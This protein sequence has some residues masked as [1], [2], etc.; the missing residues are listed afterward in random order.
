MNIFKWVKNKKE[1]ETEIEDLTANA[2]ADKATIAYY[3]NKSRGYKAKAELFEEQKD[4]YLETI[5]EQRKEIRKLKK[6]MK[7]GNK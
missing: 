2:D 5:K 4:K 3:K 6:E 7:E 1:L